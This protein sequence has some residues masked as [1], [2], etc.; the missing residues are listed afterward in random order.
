MCNVVMDCI[1]WICSLVLL[2]V[3]SVFSDH[4]FCVFLVIFAT[5]RI[6]RKSSENVLVHLY[7]YGMDDKCLQLREKDLLNPESFYVNEEKPKKEK[8]KY[9]SPHFHESNYSVVMYHGLGL[10]IPAVRSAL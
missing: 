8:G 7:G 5:T 9:P 10:G 2:R 1:E 6:I 4:L 3:F